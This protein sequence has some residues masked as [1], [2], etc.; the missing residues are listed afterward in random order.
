[1]QQRA[2]AI[3]DL[4]PTELKSEEIVEKK[5]KKGLVKMLLEPVGVVFIISPWNYPLLTLVNN[6]VAG[7]LA[8]NSIVIKHSSYTAL[9][10][11]LFED[12]FK[13]AGAPDFIVNDCFTD[14]NVCSSLFSKPEIG[15][16]GK[17][18]FFLLEINNN[19]I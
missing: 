12:A 18:L 19:E 11:K 4:A 13:W 3:I 5:S 1:M 15:Y 17:L 10:G 8:G 9:C 6:L 16:V 2:E 14:R 7:V